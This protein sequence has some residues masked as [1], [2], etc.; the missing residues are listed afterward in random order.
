M[1]DTARGMERQV[2]VWEKMFG[3]HILGKERR[4]IKTFAHCMIPF[5]YTS[6]KCKLIYSDRERIGVCL[7]LV[8]GGRPVGG[9]PQG[10]RWEWGIH[11]CTHTCGLIKLD[12]LNMSSW[13]PVNQNSK[14]F[15]FKDNVIPS[16]VHL[17]DQTQRCSGLQLIKFWSPP[18][19]SKARN[20]AVP[21]SSMSLFHF[22]Q[23][24]SRPDLPL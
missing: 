2:T 20:A 22:R 14:F 4:Q 10:A 21:K 1:K 18:S 23:E 17:F 6:G 15:F 24:F 7:A 9:H 11:R 12:T 5:L 16:P 3:R 13:L 19:A 8:R